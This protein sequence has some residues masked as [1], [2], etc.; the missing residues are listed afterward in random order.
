MRSFIWNGAPI[1]QY[2]PPLIVAV[3]YMIFVTIAAAIACA[4]SNSDKK[5][6][7][8]NGVVT[9]LTNPLVG[10]GIMVL[11]MMFG[12]SYINEAH[13]GLSVEVFAFG[14]ILNVL[15]GAMSII[16]ATVLLFIAAPDT[17]A[18]VSAAL[19]D[20]KVILG[21]Y[22][23]FKCTQALSVLVFPLC[24]IIQKWNEADLRQVLDK[25]L[26]TFDDLCKI[27]K[28]RL[29]IENQRTDQP[30]ENRATGVVTGEA[31]SNEPRAVIYGFQAFE[32]VNPAIANQFEFGIAENTALLTHNQAVELL[33]KQ[34]KLMK[35]HIL[36]LLD[37]AYR[38]YT[39]LDDFESA[40]FDVRGRPWKAQDIE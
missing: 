30:S 28:L 18:D 32:S 3:I 40:V 20:T 17:I 14:V 11:G 19:Y 5:R 4:V 7:D 38:I 26:V 33:E 16:I 36:D 24:R 10:T 37:E 27:R 21:F 8:E 23:A 6:S 1:F 34:E 13:L 39:I 2:L 9:E 31:V 22:I 35:Q 15:F 25:V 29:Q 12:V